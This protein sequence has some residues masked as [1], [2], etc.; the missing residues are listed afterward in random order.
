M[1]SLFSRWPHLIPCLIG[2]GLLF[3]AVGDR[4]YGYYELMRM[5]VTAAAL[6]TG[7]LLYRDR[8]VILLFLCIALALVFNPFVRVSLRKEQWRP[9]NI[10]GATIF[11]VLASIPRR[12]SRASSSDE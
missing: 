10:A 4:P 11:L 3:W 2:A 9:V 8:A 5:G 7:V 6:A 1:Q 12:G